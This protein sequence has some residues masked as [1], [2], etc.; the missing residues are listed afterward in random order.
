MKCVI[1]KLFHYLPDERKVQCTICG[2]CFKNQVQEK[3]HRKHV[4][5]GRYQ[6]H[7]TKCGHG[8]ARKQYLQSH[9]CGRVR[10]VQDGEKPVD[11][12]NSKPD[13]HQQK[14]QL[15]L[16]QS[17]PDEQNNTG[18][19]VVQFGT[20]PSNEQLPS[21]LESEASLYYSNQQT[22][23]FPSFTQA[24]SD[25][26]QLVQMP[27]AV[28]PSVAVNNYMPNCGILPYPSSSC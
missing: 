9:K 15:V 26:R 6:F 19:L 3:S 7:C 12:S 18:S 22:S 24:I 2:K 21:G 14:E 5:E 23:A 27:N 25:S 16:V 11:D 17:S 28:M 10:R 4:H 13:E 8:V 1:L 20:N